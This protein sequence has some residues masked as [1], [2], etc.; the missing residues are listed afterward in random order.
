MKAFIGLALIELES[1]Q[2]H[3]K[4]SKSLSDVWFQLYYPSIHL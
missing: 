1:K 3:N 4:L 2:T